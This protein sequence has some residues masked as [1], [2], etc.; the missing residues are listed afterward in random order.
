[1]SSKHSTILRGLRGMPL[2][3]GGIALGGTLTMVAVHGSSSSS[4]PLTAPN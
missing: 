1:M 2:A 3:G 4:V